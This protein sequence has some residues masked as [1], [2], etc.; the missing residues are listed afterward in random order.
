MLL[1]KEGYIVIKSMER[2]TWTNKPKQKINILI[3]AYFW[4]S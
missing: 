4:Y 3:Y 2:F 1:D